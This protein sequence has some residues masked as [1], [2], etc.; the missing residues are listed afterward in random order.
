MKAKG[1]LLGLPCYLL[2]LLQ[3]FNIKRG[4]QHIQVLIR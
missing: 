3:L 1:R 2:I 4:E